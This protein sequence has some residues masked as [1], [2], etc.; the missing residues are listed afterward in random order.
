MT[1]SPPN[2]PF[3][4]APNGLAAHAPAMAPPRTP[5]PSAAPTQLLCTLGETLLGIEALCVCE[6]TPLPWIAPV[7]GTPNGVLGVA[8]VRGAL[9]PVVELGG[10]L[11]L[12]AS[13]AHL[14]DA[15]VILERGGAM[16]AI[17]VSEVR[18]V[19]D[20]GAAHL[21]PDARSLVRAWAPTAEG[22][23][24]LLDI[25]RLFE[26]AQ[27]VAAASPG[28][29]EALASPLFRA[30]FGALDAQELETLHRRARAL[31]QGSAAQHGAPDAV[32]LM[33]A[34]ALGGEAFALD[35]SWVAEFAP[36]RLATPVP[37]SP[38]FVAGL[39]NL[40]GETLTLVDIA[41]LLGVARAPGAGDLRP[42]A[43]HPNAQVVV[44]QC[45]GVRVGLV[46]DEVLDIVGADDA[47]IAPTA[48]GDAVLRGA[49]FF[50]DTM[51]GVLD[52]P[53]LLHEGLK[54]EA[55]KL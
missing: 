12:A 55:P 23:A 10:A 43:L 13:R 8:N 33:A 52:W 22:V 17:R 24:Q 19:R 38:P 47:Q 30:V 45:D 18:E 28:S 7:A 14:S 37:C 39:M 34:F 48:T 35:L 53:R 4:A 42:D 31:S 20:V 6:V 32:R 40:R 26:R 11:G 15:L 5:V 44:T 36:L 1:L 51:L 54:V 49:V 16:V 25:D 41:A 21:A 29:D 3:S 46:V 9:V 50:R 2:A 27:T